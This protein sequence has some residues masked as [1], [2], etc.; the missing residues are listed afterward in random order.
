MICQS[1]CIRLRIIAPLVTYALLVAPYAAAGAAQAPH[2]RGPDTRASQE[3]Q[4][5]VGFEVGEPEPRRV[6][7]PTHAGRIEGPDGSRYFRFRYSAADAASLPSHMIPHSGY[8]V[9]T[10]SVPVHPDSLRARQ[11]PGFP[12]S[13]A[14]LKNRRAIG[15]QD[16]Y[17]I[18]AG[19]GNVYS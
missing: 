3:G 19:I 9:D 15:I 11:L 5:M 10:P 18:I 6:Y 1:L 2:V 12:S 4:T 7:G 17:A 16:L 13:F 14:E 8:L